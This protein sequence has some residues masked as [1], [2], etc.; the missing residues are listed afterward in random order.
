MSKYNLSTIA[1]LV[2]DTMAN[3][4]IFDD[5]DEILDDVYN[6]NA[7]DGELYHKQVIE[8]IHFLNEH[9]PDFKVNP[10]DPQEWEKEIALCRYERV[11]YGEES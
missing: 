1:M 3:A 9:H 8:G 7:E 5:Y 11:K 2:A 10:L 6:E 4:G